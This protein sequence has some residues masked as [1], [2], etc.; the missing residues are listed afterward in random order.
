MEEKGKYRN[1]R[2][3]ILENGKEK[4]RMKGKNNKIK[5]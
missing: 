4:G 3:E 5:N 2:K 1:K